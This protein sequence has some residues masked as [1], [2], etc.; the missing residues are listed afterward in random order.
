MS[1]DLTGSGDPGLVVI[2]AGLP[3]TGTMSLRMALQKLVG[4][5]YHMKTLIIES[6]GQEDAAFWKRAQARMVT[7]EV[8]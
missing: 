6:K 4:P 8:R 7:H 3:R 2:G 1:S 5:T